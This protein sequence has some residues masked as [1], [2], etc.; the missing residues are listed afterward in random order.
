VYF[1]R[2]H[3]YP[4]AQRLP[5]IVLG[6]M[7]LLA[8]K[9]SLVL[10]QGADTRTDD[11]IKACAFYQTLI[12]SIEGTAYL[13]LSVRVGW[14]LFKDL[15]TK[16]LIQRYSE[17]VS[18]PKVYSNPVYRFFMSLLN[19]FGLRLSVL[20][21]VSPIF[22]M[23]PA[24]IMYQLSHYRENTGLIGSCG[25]TNVIPNILQGTV[26]SYLLVFGLPQTFPSNS[27]LCRSN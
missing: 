14:L 17:P 4:I 13:L 20:F 23:E 19:A 27:R 22:F 10:W 25:P 2:R 12:D 18:S 16:A 6:E 7:I 24:L 26:I 3:Q 9:G 11:L 8:L 5:L 1:W 15:M 21:L